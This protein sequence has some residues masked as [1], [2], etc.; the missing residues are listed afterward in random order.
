MTEKV[1]T[2]SICTGEYED[3]QEKVYKVFRSKSEAEIYKEVLEKELK[4]RKLSIG[5]NFHDNE[6]DRE[7]HGTSVDY[8]GAW[9]F[10]KGPFDLV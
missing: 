7:F 4:E 5:D 8:T 9:I 6:N 3:R 1:Y 2:I 10:V